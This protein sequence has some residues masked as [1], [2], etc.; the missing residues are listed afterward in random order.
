MLELP[1]DLVNLSKKLPSYRQEM[2][3]DKPVLVAYVI[4]VDERGLMDFTVNWAIALEPK[5][6]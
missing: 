6:N 1:N 3:T 4:K 5:S 2:E